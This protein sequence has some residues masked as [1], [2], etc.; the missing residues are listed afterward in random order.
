MKKKDE[1]N[2]KDE[3]NLKIG[4]TM[5]QDIEKRKIGNRKE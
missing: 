4:Q 5:R 2:E 3:E 1:K